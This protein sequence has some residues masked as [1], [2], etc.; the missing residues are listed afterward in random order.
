MSAGGFGNRRAEYGRIADKL[1]CGSLREIG[2][3]ELD[4]TIGQLDD[5]MLGRRLRHLVTENQRAIDMAA[6]LAVDDWTAVGAG[7]SAAHASMR[8][9]L[10][11]SCPQVDLAV[12]AIMANGGLGARL[13]GG[14]FGGC[15][16]A[17]VP[18]G[19]F[20][21]A[22]DGV[23]TAF[24]KAGFDRPSAFVAR[25]GGPANRDS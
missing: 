23:R 24:A 18:T 16:S 10:E 17:V 6:A 8:D 15:V 4:Q 22:R 19:D 3:A 5:P 14:G 13:V 7:M 25:A 9:D 21:R 2:P 11:V 12:S 20:E 1:G